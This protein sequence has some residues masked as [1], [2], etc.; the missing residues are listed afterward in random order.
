MR[1]LL[2]ASCLLLLI[3]TGGCV[4]V[5]PGCG[6]QG[7]ATIIVSPSIVLISVGEQVTPSA[8]R[9]CYSH[10]DP[11]YPHWS[12]ADLADTSVVRLD[13]SSGRITGRRP[14]QAVVVAHSDDAQSASITVTVR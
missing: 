11:A 1:R 5:D 3:G 7:G 14:G 2:V 8:S 6:N 12:L 10:R 4:I 9:G 13:A